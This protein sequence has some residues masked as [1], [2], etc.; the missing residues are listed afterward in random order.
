VA[1][2]PGEE[3]LLSAQVLRPQERPS[4]QVALVEGL[5]SRVERPCHGYDVEVLDAAKAQK[6]GRVHQG[7]PVAHVGLEEMPP[8]PERGLLPGA[9]ES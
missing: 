6:I 5:P 8:R 1:V 3:A 9:G 2:E 7:K 4:E